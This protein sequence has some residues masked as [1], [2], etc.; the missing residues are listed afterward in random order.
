LID[1]KYLLHLDIGYNKISFEDTQVL[2]EMLK[3]NNTL[4]GIHYEGN[5]GKIDSLG[6][7]IPKN[8]R[9]M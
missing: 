2:S 3:E 8:F 6:F 9:E 7:L 1:N 5:E 4:H